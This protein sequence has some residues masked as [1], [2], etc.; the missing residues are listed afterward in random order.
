[1]GPFATTRQAQDGS[2]KI[3]KSRKP[4]EPRNILGR[5]TRLDTSRIGGLTVSLRLSRRR[6][7][8]GKDGST[9][10]A[11]PTAPRPTQGC[12]NGP[13]QAIWLENAAIGISS[14]ACDI[15]A[16]RRSDLNPRASVLQSASFGPIVG[17]CVP[18]RTSDSPRREKGLSPV[19]RGPGSRPH[20]R[21]K[22]RCD[23][24]RGLNAL[25]IWRLWAI[26]SAAM[27][28][29]GRL[30]RWRS[31]NSAAHGVFAPWAN[32]GQ[33]TGFDVSHPPYRPAGY[34]GEWCN[35]PIC[36]LAGSAQVCS[37]EIE[38]AS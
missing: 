36:R 14:A 29:F 10:A 15:F 4:E 31:G 35:A 23:H 27:E 34:A 24:A 38:S 19:S 6:N 2:Q 20:R 25:K 28:E 1:M 8:A 5:R 37:T 3:E 30:R 21:C 33:R 13:L 16:K 26:D 32:E 18:Y 17:D 7:A 9:S 22:L 11:P 12:K